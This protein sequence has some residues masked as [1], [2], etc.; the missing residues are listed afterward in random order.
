MYFNVDR[1]TH[2]TEP[3][4][5]EHDN[6]DN[7][8]LAQILAHLFRREIRGSPAPSL[9]QQR[10]HSMQHMSSF[11]ANLWYMYRRKLDDGAILLHLPMS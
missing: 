4:S 7:Q 3:G 1:C 11:L 9:Q 8:S 10:E 2:A 5:Q 6:N